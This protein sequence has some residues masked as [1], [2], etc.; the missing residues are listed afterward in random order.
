MPKMLLLV[1]C[2]WRGIMGCSGGKSSRPILT[3]GLL[4]LLPERN[5]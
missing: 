5:K 4:N 1:F 2:V 3:S